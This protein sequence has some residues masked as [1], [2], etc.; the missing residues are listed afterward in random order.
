MKPCGN[1]EA[2]PV[3][4]DPFGLGRVEPFVEPCLGDQLE[5]LVFMVCDP[6]SRCRSEYANRQLH[7]FDE[8]LL[9]GLEVQHS[10]A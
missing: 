5:S 6:G 8:H 4:G 7:G 3:E 10:I 9:I 1:R 2:R